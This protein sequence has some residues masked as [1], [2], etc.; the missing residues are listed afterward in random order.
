[1]SLIAVIDYK[2]IAVAGGITYCLNLSFKMA[3]PL[4][5]HNIAR[6][7]SGL[8]AFIHTKR[9]KPVGFAE[10]KQQLPINSF[11]KVIALW[12]V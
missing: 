8:Q 9:L 11:N 1:M 3:P 4:A 5:I 2:I 10:D 6:N 12:V 7:P